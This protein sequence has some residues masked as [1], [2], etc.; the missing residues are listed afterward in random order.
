MSYGK[1]IDFLFNQMRNG[2]NGSLAAGTA[3]FYDAGTTTPRAVWTNRGM[4]TPTAAGLLTPVT[5]TAD[6][7]AELYGNGVYRIVI[8]DS[9][10]ATIYDYDDVEIQSIS[11]TPGTTTTVVLN[12]VSGSVNETFTAGTTDVQVLR[13]DATANQAIV[14]LPNGYTIAGS[15]DTT[16]ELYTQGESVYLWLNDTTYYVV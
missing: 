1:S 11:T 15:G 4:T 12:A 9:T 16:Y 14:T 8:K 13:T 3:T 6:G 2:S 7:T 10:G 5:L